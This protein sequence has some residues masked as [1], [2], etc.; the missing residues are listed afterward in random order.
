MAAMERVRGIG[1]FLFRSSDPAGLQRMI[2][3]A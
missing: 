2:K 3:P 1:G